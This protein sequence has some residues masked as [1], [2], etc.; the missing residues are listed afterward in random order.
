L[1]S[2][3]TNERDYEVEAIDHTESDR[4]AAW[5]ADSPD[6]VL[7]DLNLPDDLTLGIM[8]SIRQLGNRTRVVLLVPDDHD[9]LVE[10][11]AEGAHGCVLERSSLEELDRAITRALDGENFCSPDIIGSMFSELTR[12]KSMLTK[13]PYD[14]VAERRLTARE[15]EVL[16][17]LEKRKSN[18]EIA[19]ELC[20][21]LF[22]VKNH[23]HNILEKLNVD[24]RIEAVEVARQHN[25]LSRS[26]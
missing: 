7:L 5:V 15:L 25:R 9:R 23:V 24:N 2:F 14:G 6:L 17:L 4:V 12:L 22:T 26:S 13:S 20:V 16:E 19:A 8:R 3:L 18:K 21:S 10:C 1:A 11:I